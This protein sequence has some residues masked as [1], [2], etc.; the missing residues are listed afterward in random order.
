MKGFIKEFKEFALKGSVM[1]LAVGMI[2]GSAFT[3]LVTSFVDN[4]INPII[5]RFAGNLDFSNLFISLDGKHYETLKAAEDAGAAVLKYG[6]F[7][8]AFLNFLI[9]AFVIFL[10]MKAVNKAREV[11]APKEEPA[12][13]TTK[14]CPYCKSEI[15]ID[16]V[17]CPNCTSRLKNIDIDL[18]PGEAE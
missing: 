16:A 7:I 5:G 2:I 15:A 6:T 11:T 18:E 14:I 17:R 8:S 3:A 13:P 4:I 12:A 10:M 9:M 1:D